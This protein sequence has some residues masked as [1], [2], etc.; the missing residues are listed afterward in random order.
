VRYGNKSWQS[1]F[2]EIWIR[3]PNFQ[4][5]LLRERKCERWVPCCGIKEATLGDLRCAA[6]GWEEWECVK[7]E[8]S[9]SPVVRQSE[10]LSGISA[11]LRKGGKAKG[12]GNDPP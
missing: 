7:G 6:K 2:G 12:P 5:D 3:L 11:S 1:G 8:K 4:K 10:Q 9:G